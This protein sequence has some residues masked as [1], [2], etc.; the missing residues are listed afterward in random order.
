MI[1]RG[2]RA[3]DRKQISMFH[4]LRAASMAAIGSLVF[5]GFAAAQGDEPA[6]RAAGPSGVRAAIDDVEQYY[7]APL[8]WD[9]EDWTYFAVAVGAVVAAHQ[10]D[11]TV[12][13]H[14]AV[15]SH[16]LLGA[17]DKNS[18]RDALPSVALIAGTWAAAGYMGDA[19]GYSETWRL[20]EAGVLSTAT[21]EAMALAGGRLRP[22]T[23]ISP[24]QW[25]K[26]GDS[27]PSVHASAAFAIGMTFA[28]SGSDDYRWVRRLLGYSV[29]AGTAYIRI[30]DNVHWVSDTVG[31][32]A[33]GIATARFV[34]NRE[35]G[36]TATQ[37][38]GE[39]SLQPTHAGW[40]LSYLVP[41]H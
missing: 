40:T 1:G 27:F 29:T 3:I 34:I 33:L 35:N 20:F 8:H 31:G 11:T 38:R 16:A 15:G 28:E 13:N 36:G 30:K 5:A 17:K 7:T 37:D 26:G 23:T 22:D 25:R 18:T 41:L 6:G 21:G 10:A 14:F 9:A 4:S 2:W 32:A 12:R 24:D 19:E 39:L